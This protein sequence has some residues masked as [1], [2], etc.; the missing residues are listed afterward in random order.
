MEI[1]FKN[2][3]IRTFNEHNLCIEGKY[4]EGSK[5]AGEWKEDGDGRFFGRIKDACIALLHLDLLESEI[6]SVQGLLDNI[7]RSEHKVE[8]IVTEA[9]KEDVRI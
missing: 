5:R 6:D 8:R 7:I 2:Y 1:Q 4:S 3:R 9:K